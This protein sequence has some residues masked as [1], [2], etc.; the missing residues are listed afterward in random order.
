MKF[1]KII[2]LLSALF[3]SV[4]F[5]QLSVPQGGT[6]KTSFP[7]NSLIYSDDGTLQRLQATSS[8]TIGSFTATSTTAT[9]T[10]AGNLQVDGSMRVNGVLYIN[11]SAYTSFT[12]GSALFAGAS[13]VLAQDNANF[14]FDDTNNWLGVGTNAPSERLHVAGVAKLTHDIIVGANASSTMIRTSVNGG[15][16]RLLGDSGTVNR[17]VQLGGVDNNG[18][19]YPQLT[20]TDPAQA[21]ANV[22]ISSTS[23]WSKFA[24]TNT[25]TGPSFVVEDET[26]SDATPF[27]VTA[28]GDVGVGTPNPAAKLT[29]K[30]TSQAAG[31]GLRFVRS[32]SDSE[33]FDV[34][35][36]LG[37]NV[38]TFNDPLLIGTPFAATAFLLSRDGMGYFASNVG[39]GIT[40]PLN[41]LTV[42]TGALEVSGAY[43]SP[44]GSSVI[45]SQE[46]THAQLQTFGSKPLAINPLGNNVGLGTTTPAV[47]LHIDSNLAGGLGHYI[48]NANTGV[49]GRAAFLLG[50]SLS[51]GN[52]VLFEH[53]SPGFTTDGLRVANRTV[54]TGADTGGFA[55][56]TGVGAP[57]MFHTGGTADANERL[58]ITSTGLVG[59][60][61]ST[62]TSLFQTFSTGTST[63]SVD[64]SALAKGS[65]LEMKDSDGVGYTYITAN[66]GVLTAS[67]ISCK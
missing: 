9:S 40:S 38:G 63:I 42:A 20:I 27:M 25:G 10:I 62:P 3:P 2:V 21:S 49:A 56:G 54:L 23:P 22:G 47:A 19:F 24:V 61:T 14:F 64:S 50:Q 52:Y 29:I 26:S 53:L 30:Q 36:L 58:R 15:A 8:P 44:I 4:V 67:T 7:R 28:S 11:G 46:T 59:I 48:T 37:A 57:L 60:G 33:F 51:D 66:N 39:I 12:Q 16:I 1:F 65:C 5:A 55:I 32:N 43:V 6:G 31:G 18:V 34:V 13:G 17:Y 41:K 45:L 35:G